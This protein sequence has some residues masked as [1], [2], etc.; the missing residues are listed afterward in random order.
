MEAVHTRAGAPVQL[1][2]PQE[3]LLDVWSVQSLGFSPSYQ[4]TRIEAGWMPLIIPSSH[5]GHD[6]ACYQG[7]RWIPRG[8]EPQGLGAGGQ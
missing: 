8:L 5:S 1:V 6:T 7:K 2:P 4:L 3:G